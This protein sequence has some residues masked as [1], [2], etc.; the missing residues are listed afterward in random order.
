M[1]K[2]KKKSAKK[3]APKKAAPKKAARKKSASRRP[4]SRPS[5]D[6]GTPTGPMAEPTSTESSMEQPGTTNTND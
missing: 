3:T 1:A 6:M 4:A 2:A 5:S